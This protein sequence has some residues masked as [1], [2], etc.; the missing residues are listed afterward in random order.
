MISMLRGTQIGVVLLVTACGGGDGSG[1]S[2]PPIAP[3]NRAPLPVVLASANPA[4]SSQVVTLNGVGSTDPDGTIASFSWT[5]TAGPDITL[6]SANTSTAT[7]VAPP[8]ATRATL[9]FKL[10]VTDNA[11]AVGSAEI[12]VQVDP[13]PVTYSLTLQTAKPFVVDDEIAPIRRSDALF[14]GTTIVPTSVTWTSDI[15]GDLS[16][17]VRGVSTLLR[18]GVHS[19]QATA[20]FGILG[21]VAKTLAVR[22]LPRKWPVS[23]DQ[24]TPAANASVVVPIVLINYLPT[25]DGISID[26]TVTG[27]SGTSEW[28]PGTV[29]ALQEWIST[30][31][32][33]A[34]FMLEEGSRYRGYKNAASVPYL[35]Y[36]IVD[37][38]NYYEEMPAGFPDPGTAG[39]VFPDYQVILGRI[40]SQELVESQGVR[41]FWL[42]SYHHGTFSLN[43]SNM[44]SPTTGD[45][46]NSWREPSD[47]PLFSKTYILYQN[48]YTRSHAEAVH[49]HGHQIEAMMA[50]INFIRD[51]NTNLF[52]RQFVGLNANQLFEPGRCGATHFP[53]NAT[54]DYDYNNQTNVVQS[55]CEDWKPDGTGTKKTSTLS[56]WASIHYAWPGASM[57]SQKYESQWYIYWM[58][59]LPGA[60]NTIP[61]SATTMEN[62]WEFIS[63]WDASILGGKRLYK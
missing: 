63:D 50:H 40:P 7:L 29:T 56:T 6:G 51:G 42:Y 57:V 49:N 35:G 33:R 30:I 32:T 25:R 55:D 18:A 14:D 34:K 5:Q 8:V 27:P 46:S 41:E 60:G 3:V 19:I 43:E 38:Y 16:G 53:L 36:R 31:T 28:S 4:Y 62:W 22:V 45:I 2:P 54:A 20:D 15:Q 10:L 37:I 61:Y 12:N 26:S 17:D 58:Q 23:S 59:N 1:S 21:S 9:T 13:A 24:T 11:G 48:N 52:W 44:S 47:L 39:N